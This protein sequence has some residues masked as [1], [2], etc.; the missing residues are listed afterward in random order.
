[1]RMNRRAR[2]RGQK[3]RKRRMIKQTTGRE[4]GKKK[5]RRKKWN[6]SAMIKIRKTDRAKTIRGQKEEYEGW[7]SKV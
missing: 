7:K 1:M 2:R 4:V 6:K 3:E 5:K